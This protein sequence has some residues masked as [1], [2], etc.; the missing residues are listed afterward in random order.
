MCQNENNKPPKTITLSH[1]IIL[2]IVTNE[3]AAKSGNPNKISK[4]AIPLSTK[5]NPPGVGIVVRIE[6]VKVVNTIIHMEI[7]IFIDSATK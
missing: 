1:E 6:E 5:P 3:T 4:A 2:S 7:S